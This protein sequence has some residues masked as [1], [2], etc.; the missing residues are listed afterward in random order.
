MLP[1]SDQIR[2]QEISLVCKRSVNSWIYR[3]VSELLA[4]VG[5]NSRLKL[6][7]NNWRKWNKR[8]WWIS[9]LSLF[10]N[11]YMREKKRE[12]MCNFGSWGNP[13]C[14]DTDRTG[15]IVWQ[16]VKKCSLLTKMHSQFSGWKVRVNIIYV[17]II[18]MTFWHF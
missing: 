15:S 16:G 11:W 9:L 8:Y 3:K 6:M 14:L 5:H 4:A 18:L 10:S 13:K 12:L 17:Y 7:I 2:L 1:S